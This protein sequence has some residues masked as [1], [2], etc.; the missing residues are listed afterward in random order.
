MGDNGTR[1][2]APHRLTSEGVH[3]L[4]VAGPL[5]TS[6]CRRYTLWYCTIGS[7]KAR[8]AFSYF[9]CAQEENSE[10]GTVWRGKQARILFNTA[11]R[12]SSVFKPLCR[13]IAF[14]LFSRKSLRKGRIPRQKLF[15]KEPIFS[16]SRKPAKF[17]RP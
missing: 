11:T 15:S 1:S 13:K 7:L 9:S 4:R 2:F 8:F 5:Q 10:K 17:E 12:P 14:L 6:P 16:C 3:A